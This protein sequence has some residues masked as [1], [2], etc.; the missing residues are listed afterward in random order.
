[1]GGKKDLPPGMMNGGMA[2]KDKK[3]KMG[4]KSKGYRMGG[5]VK[6]KGDKVGGKI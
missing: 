5:K 6:K 4:M 3:K 1:M 2:E